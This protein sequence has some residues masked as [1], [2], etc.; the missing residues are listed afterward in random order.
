[1]RTV[2]Q[3]S[4]INAGLDRPHTA[5]IWASE[6]RGRTPPAPGNLR[7]CGAR[8][9]GLRD[10]EVSV[11]C[12][13]TGQNVRKLSVFVLKLSAGCLFCRLGCPKRAFSLS[14]TNSVNN[15]L[16]PWL[17]RIGG[18]RPLPLG[19]IRCSFLSVACDRA[20]Q[21][22]VGRQGVPARPKQPGGRLGLNCRVCDVCWCWQFGR[23]LLH[24]GLHRE[25]RRVPPSRNSKPGAR[26][27]IF[28][29]PPGVKWGQ[30]RVDA[31]A[32]EPL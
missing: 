24:R 9:V 16:R 27:P 32:G 30:V 6:R 10:F 22:P 1:M 5:Q 12:P 3:P 25:G 31:N 29:P 26:V 23:R 11:T 20:S 7:N 17:Q 8:F 15:C 4:L 13:Q 14:V 28:V 18:K 21:G 2:S 19:R